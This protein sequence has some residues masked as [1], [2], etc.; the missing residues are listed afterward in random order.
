MGG[1]KAL[2]KINN[3]IKASAESPDGEEGGAENGLTDAQAQAI[4]RMIIE[5][6]HHIK[7]K[8]P[9]GAG[10]Q[11][12]SIPRQKNTPTRIN[13]AFPKL[14]LPAKAKGVLGTLPL[15]PVRA[16]KKDSEDVPTTVQVG[17]P[18]LQKDG[19]KQKGASQANQV[20]TKNTVNQGKIPLLNELAQGP[21]KMRPVPVLKGKFV[22]E[23]KKSNPEKIRG[24]GLGIAGTGN[25]P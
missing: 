4:E 6:I 3:L 10:T 2:E 19:P 17:V 7:K 24:L 25:S 12:A 18:R 14:R 9:D 1:L 22:D 21:G 11:R 5:G 13:K 15:K 8:S 23:R 20:E 16:E